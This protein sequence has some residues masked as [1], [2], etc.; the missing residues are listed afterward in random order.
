MNKQPIQIKNASLCVKC[1]TTIGMYNINLH[2]ILVAKARRKNPRMTG[3]KFYDQMMVVTSRGGGHRE[4]GV[5]IVKK[6]YKFH[7]QISNNNEYIFGGLIWDTIFLLDQNIPQ[8][9]ISRYI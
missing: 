2:Q 1:V 8:N 7:M 4:Q 3:K 6:N 5:E 9:R